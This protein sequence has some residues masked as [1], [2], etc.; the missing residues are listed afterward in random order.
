MK[1]NKNVLSFQIQSQV[2]H[3]FGSLQADGSYS[4]MLGAV[5]RKVNSRTI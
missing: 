2:D 1:C 4:G 5:A 3:Q